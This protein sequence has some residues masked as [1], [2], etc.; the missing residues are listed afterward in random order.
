MTTP[1]LSQ[2]LASLLGPDSVLPGGGYAVDEVVP[3]AVVRP[4]DRA[5]VSE[6]LR[7]ASVN[8]ANV[9]PRGGGVFVHLG[10]VPSRVDVALDLS[11]LDRVVDFQ[12]EDLTVSVEAGITLEAL[13]RELTREGKYVP[14]E[15][16]LPQA[17]TVGG[18]L[19]TGFSGPMR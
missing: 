18:I 13:R 9:F 17:A 12:P 5:A 15:A 4:A 6:V 16:P 11:A 10:N 1:N 3:Q 14:L 2:Q 8:G 7:W 19:A